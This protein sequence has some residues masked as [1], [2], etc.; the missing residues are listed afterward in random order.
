[1]NKWWKK[2]IDERQQAE[3]NR[4]TG[5]GYWIAFYL[6]LAAIIWEG[7]IQGR[8]FADWQAEWIV[9]MILAVYE[10]AASFR[11]GVWTEC[12]PA[13]T[14][15]SSALYALSGSVIFAVIFTFSR[16]LHLEEA[17]RSPVGLACTFAV[18]MVLLFVLFFGAFLVIGTLFNRRERRLKQKMDQ[19]LTEDEDEDE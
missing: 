14:P 2:K 6:L 10:V 19:E 3:L 4:V 8:P 11:I 15:K 5:I 12:Q 16:W 13:P 9:F 1:M 17:N 18:W 7:L